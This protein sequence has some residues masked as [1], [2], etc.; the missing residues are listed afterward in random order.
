MAKVE[1]G[2]GQYLYFRETDAPQP[3]FDN[4]H[5]Q[6]YVADFSGPYRKLGERNLVSQED[7]RYQYRFRDIVD[8]ESG[9]LLFTIE[10]EVRSIRHPNYLRPLVN[11]NPAQMPRTYSPNHDEFELVDGTGADGH[12]LGRIMGWSGILSVGRC[13]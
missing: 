11:R 4:H 3:E 8:L 10:H 1:V 12:A 6:I 5:I 7:N 13:P 2:Q 9:K